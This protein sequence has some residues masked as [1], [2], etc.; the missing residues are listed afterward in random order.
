MQN[1]FVLVIQSA[2]A[3]CGEILVFRRNLKRFKISTIG[4][5]ITTDGLN[6]CRNR[7]G[8]ETTATL[9][10]PLFQRGNRIGDGD[11]LKCGVG[12]GLYTNGF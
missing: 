6:T 3:V 1:G 12:K 5:C 4:K 7:K 2:V 10:G 11:L 9:K 8:G